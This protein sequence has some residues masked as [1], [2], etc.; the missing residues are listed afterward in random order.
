MA[1]YQGFTF[2]LH[3]LHQQYKLFNHKE[4]RVKANFRIAYTRKI[5]FHQCIVLPRDSIFCEIFKE[6]MEGEGGEGK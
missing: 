3:C 5:C 4:L 2:C 1:F 6:T